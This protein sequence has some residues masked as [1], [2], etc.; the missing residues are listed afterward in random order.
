M[1]PHS[2]LIKNIEFVPIGRAEN[3]TFTP[4]VEPD[5]DAELQDVTVFLEGYFDDNGSYPDAIAV[6][7]T[8][9]EAIEK[10]AARKEM[11]PQDAITYIKV[12]GSLLIDDASVPIG[13]YRVFEMK[14][15]NENRG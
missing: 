5:S 9:Y 6:N 7:P 1:I 11:V 14:P 15:V 13:V 10:S 8:V 4:C 2:N 12:H 3:V